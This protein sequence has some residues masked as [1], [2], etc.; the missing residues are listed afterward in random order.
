MDMLKLAISSR[1]PM[2]HVKTDD[3][4]NVK[5]ILDFIAG[6]DVVALKVKDD[7]SVSN[8]DSSDVFF[9]SSDCSTLALQSVYI[10]MKKHKKTV[11]FVN[12]KPSVL[13]FQGGT[14]LPPKGMILAELKSHTDDQTAHEILPAFGGMTLKDTFEVVMMTLK[15]YG[16]LTTKGVNKIRQSYVCKLKGISQVDT[17]FSFY[18]SPSYLE[19]WCA[20]NLGFFTN[21]L[22]SDLTPRG[23]LFD[24][25]P[26][27]G[28]SMGAKYIANR[29]GVPLYRLDI[30][31]MKGKYVGDS[32]GNLNAALTQIDQSEPCV[33]I[34]D[35][36]EKIFTTGTSGGDA[37]VT[38]GMLSTLLWWLQEH[39]TRVFSV[40]TTNNVKAIPPELYREGRINATMV[41]SG[42]EKEDHA[43]DFANSVID[44]VLSTVEVS[45]GVTALIQI[46]VRHKVSAMFCAGEPIPQVKVSEA[47]FESIKTMLSSGKED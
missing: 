47:V 14:L 32:E 12:S 42:I 36:V 19:D 27:T 13:H 25:P 30:G 6:V 43:Q 46:D 16:N 45:D 17:D 34:F 10:T 1:L 31:A 20:N 3:L 26:G 9:F 11:V 15:R 24:G 18:Q 39:K 33:V 8:L 4:L 22:H 35:E 40:M 21:Q 37:G 29:L 28:K 5:K 2:I 41:F 7:A 38:S 23:L 44:S